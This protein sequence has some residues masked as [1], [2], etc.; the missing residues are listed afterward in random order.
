MWRSCAADEL[1][2]SASTSFSLDGRSRSNTP[3]P[4]KRALFDDT[5]YAPL[6][7][8]SS[9]E[10]YE[11]SAVPVEAGSGANERGQY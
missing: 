10:R 2:G 4:A 11:S 5:P 1:I 3:T 9:Q 6:V 8:N 7:M